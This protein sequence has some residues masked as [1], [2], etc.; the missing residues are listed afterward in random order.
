LAVACSAKTNQCQAFARVHNSAA[1]ARTDTL[2]AW[3]DGQSLGDQDLNL[4]AKRSL[5]LSFVV[6]RGTRIVRAT[7]TRT[8]AL[9][10]D[11]TAVAL[12]PSPPA[13]QVLLVSDTPG[14]L[15]RALRDVPGLSVRVITVEAYEAS[16]A[17]GPDLV[18]MDNVAPPNFPATPLLMIHP[19]ADSGLVNVRNANVFLPMALPDPTDP[20]VADLDLDGMAG[21]GEA[22]DT[23]AW[24]TVDAGTTSMPL[25]LHGSQGGHRTV[26]L[27]FEPSA[28]A[29][30][31]DVAFPLLIERLVRWLI[32]PPAATIAAG[33]ALWLPPNV[34]SV[35]S[36]TG[37]V[38]AGPLIN[39]PSPGLYRVA[40][41]NGST[42]VGTPLFAVSAAA[43]GDTAPASVRVPTWV[44]FAGIAGLPRSFWSWALL[45]ALIA[46][47]GEWVYYARK[48]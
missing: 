16:D 23:P 27:P 48:T 12:S 47:S 30:A 22:I 8:D 32:P 26:V 21:N 11:N 25:I 13:L 24:A 19:P 38:L 15:L 40:E 2:A 29:F 39:P 28:G 45:A 18:V 7:L 14:P 42:S 3:A 9:P 35:R 44:P 10:G 34:Q 4:P 37:E 6:P 41:P 46:L 1:M 20:L 43:P 17:I 33:T 5:E 36:P 31:Q